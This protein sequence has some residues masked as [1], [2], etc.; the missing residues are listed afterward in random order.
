MFWSATVSVAARARVNDLKMS[1]TNQ[2]DE[3]RLAREHRRCV[4]ELKEIARSRS[5]NRGTNIRGGT[6]RLKFASIAE[7]VFLRMQTSV[8]CTA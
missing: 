6:R 3:L 7:K 8:L 4:A 1:I 2:T 5:I